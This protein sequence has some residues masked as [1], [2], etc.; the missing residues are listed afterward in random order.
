[1]SNV[2]E[3]SGLQNDPSGII[4]ENNTSK[5]SVSIDTHKRLL[6]QYKNNQDKLA[7]L[8]AEKESQYLELQKA[9]GKK[10]EVIQA[11]EKKVRDLEQQNFGLFQNF[12]KKTILGEVTKEVLSKGIQPDKLDKFM[13]LTQENFLS[14]ESGLQIDENFNILNKEVFS[15]IL[16]SQVNDNQDWFT[17]SATQPRDV[18]P[19]GRPMIVPEKGLE[20]KSMDELANML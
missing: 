16:D 3:P 14:K 6:A 8:E 10:D 13:K 4:S 15:K 1:M 12:T 2:I 5:D 20:D 17:R 19:E 9:E 11:Y 7:S 18:V